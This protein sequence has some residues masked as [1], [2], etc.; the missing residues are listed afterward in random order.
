MTSLSS[1]Y[2]LGVWCHKKNSVTI[3]VMMKKKI[4]TKH[5]RPAYLAAAGPSQ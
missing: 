3:S 2:R 5:A 1:L 4:T